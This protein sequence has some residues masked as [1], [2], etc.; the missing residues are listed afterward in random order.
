MTVKE[1]KDVTDEE[2][3]FEFYS[4]DSLKY[5]I[6]MLSQ[7]KFSLQKILPK[8]DPLNEKKV[9][10]FRFEI[11]ARYCQLAES[12][13]GLILGYKNLNITSN[14]QLNKNHTQQVLKYLSEYTINDID[15]FYKNIENNSL[16][17]DVIFGYDLLDT[18]YQN[19][20][21]IS[22]D[23]IKNNLKQIANC[24]L[25]YKNSYNAYK[26]GYRLWVGKEQSN[27]IEAAIFRNRKGL[28]DYIP[29][30]DQ[31]L[32]L[33]IKSGTYCLNL[34]DIL[35]SNHKSIFYYLINNGN[36]T[37]PIKFLSDLENITEKNVVL[38]NMF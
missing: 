9:L 34:F 26:H 36:K 11:I 23:N 37:L 15:T 1:R 18:K 4:L 38:V 12:L 25:F 13:G 10:I 19:E 29:L 22:R 27:H 8:N 16:A 24:Y 3:L 14:K 17:Y 33:V 20:I 6:D 2:I 35:K 32:N 30:D 5:L 31:S 7:L 21:L 28:E